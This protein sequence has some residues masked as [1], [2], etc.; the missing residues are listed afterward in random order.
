MSRIKTWLKKTPLYPVLRAVRNAVRPKSRLDRI[1]RRDAAHTAA[2]LARA[3]QPGGNAVDVGAHAGDVLAE[4]VRLSPAGRHVAV[5]AIPELAAR[6]RAAFPGVAVH[7]AAAGEA[8]GTAEFQWVTTNPAYSGL[9]RRADL[10]AE[11]AVTAVT[12]PIVRVD[13]L[14]PPGVRVAVLKIDVEGAELGVLRGAARV[15]AESRPWVLLEHG[16][17]AAVYGTTTA[18]V[19]AEFARHRMS[20][21]L[22]GDWLAGRPPLSA[23]GFAAAVASGDYWNFLAGPTPDGT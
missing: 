18:A 15:L 22:M 11:D 21:W 16:S 4:F 9:K 1:E 12:V 8:P 10:R 6:L 7:A 23:D 17:A 14:V 5:E 20:V 13:D 2:V 19:A 3:L